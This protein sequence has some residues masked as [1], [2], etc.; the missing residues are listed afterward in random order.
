MASEDFPFLYIQVPSSSRLV[1]QRNGEAWAH[2]ALGFSTTVESRT[3]RYPAVV[4]G[5][6]GKGRWGI[7]LY[8]LPAALLVFHQG[9]E[10]FASDGDFP[11]PIRDGKAR[12]IYLF[13]GVYSPELL[14]QP[15]PSFHE[16]LVVRMLRRL[17][18]DFSPL[19]RV[20]YYPYPHTTC[21]LLSGDSDSLDKENLLKAWKRL[22]DWGAPYTQF[23]MPEDLKPFSPR[24]LADWQDRDI[25]FGLHYY[26]GDS[27]SEEE[28]ALGIREDRRVFSG[29]GLELSSARGHSLIWVG[30]DGQ[31]RAFQRSD[32][33]LDSSISFI[34]A[35]TAR[36]GEGL[37]F[38]LFT[39]E[40]A[41]RVYEISATSTSDD[42]ACHDKSGH[43][44][45]KVEEALSK[46]LGDLEICRRHT[47]QPLNLLFHP[48]YLVGRSS[49][50]TSLWVE[51][52]VVR[53]RELSIPVYN[54]R[55]W[56]EFW[57]RR[58]K[59]SVKAEVEEYVVRMKVSGPANG[60]G[61]ALPSRWAG[62]ELRVEGVK[63]T[64]DEILVPA[65]ETEV[66]YE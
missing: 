13:N 53:C 23:I 9:Y 52:M 48:H 49:P 61:I 54:F 27:P 42:V 36:T 63:L 58:E 38:R 11:M 47:Y 57:W 65:W 10:F 33:R 14:L 55:Q 21:L 34:W 2:F 60:T 6:E 46:T 24:E 18:D 12:S 3:S 4:W 17:T 37:P 25:D 22:A 29:K 15:Q 1:R 26:H 50:D 56:M 41:S 20:W 35:P 44:P 62:K 59:M 64:T 51:R 32:I 28:M 7:F 40:G 43:L 31:I 30:W 19:P 39:R 45:M 16:H 5:E 66:R 8:D